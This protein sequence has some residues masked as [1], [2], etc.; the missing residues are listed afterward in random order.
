MKIFPKNSILLSSI[1]AGLL[2]TASAAQALYIQHMYEKDNLWVH[3]YHT[4]ATQGGCDLSPSGSDSMSVLMEE[5]T[6]S[7]EGTYTSFRV[8][9]NTGNGSVCIKAEYSTLHNNYY[10]VIEASTKKEDNCKITF[11]KKSGSDLMPVIV[12]SKTTQN[13]QENVCIVNYDNCT[14][15]E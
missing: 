13:T 6:G 10:C 4:R 15:V 5:A 14:V 1:A 2:C 9:D 8:P 11:S 7:T 12:K 3:V